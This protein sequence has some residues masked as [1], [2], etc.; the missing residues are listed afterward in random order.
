MHGS[1]RMNPSG[2]RRG[3]GVYATTSAER[4]LWEEVR[5]A[6]VRGPACAFNRD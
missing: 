3:L 2:Q 4:L 6:R 1:G 5:V